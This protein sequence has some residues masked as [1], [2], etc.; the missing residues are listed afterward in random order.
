MNARPK[1]KEKF[2]PFEKS[3]GTGLLGLSGDSGPSSRFVKMFYLRQ[4]AEFHVPVTDIERAKSLISSLLETV[5]I[6]Y[7]TVCPA[8]NERENSSEKS[9]SQ[10]RPSIINMLFQIV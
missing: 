2:V 9:C 6:P 7:G 8:K 3:H 10:T 1:P 5:A 4:L